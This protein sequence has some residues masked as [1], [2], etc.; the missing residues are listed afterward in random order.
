MCGLNYLFLTNLEVY[1]HSQAPCRR[2]GQDA[3]TVLFMATTLTWISGIQRLE[4]NLTQRSKKATD[5][6]DTP[7]T[8]VIDTP[9][10]IDAPLTGMIN[11]PLT[12]QGGEIRGI[13]PN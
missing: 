3:L 8:A 2:R 9:L 6:I 10:T 4:T 11:T 5:V 12:I 7:L 13:R 1:R